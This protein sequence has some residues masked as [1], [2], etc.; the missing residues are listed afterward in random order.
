MNS[1]TLYSFLI[2]LFCA[3]SAS[4]A[5]Y[6]VSCAPNCAP[7]S[8]GN[9]YIQVDA[10][11]LAIA[12]NAVV[13]DTIIVVYPHPDEPFEDCIRISAYWTVNHAPVTGYAHLTPYS[14]LYC[15]EP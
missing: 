3:G 10:T 9:P 5:S 13:G 11:N 6:N 14:Y 15:T 7:F 4:A 8:Y 1:N 2:G 12:S